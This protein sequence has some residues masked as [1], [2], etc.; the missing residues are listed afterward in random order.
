MRTL[1]G[2]SAY[3][4]AA[5]VGV[6][7]AVLI[8]GGVWWSLSDHPEETSLPVEPR[9]R[10]VRA[11]PRIAYVGRRTCAE[12]H[13]SQ[14]ETYLKTTHSRAL[15]DVDPSAEPPD[16]E[17]VHEPSQRAYRVYRRDGELRHEERL[18]GDDGEGLRLA[19]HPVKYVIGSGNHSRSYLV[20][21]DGF[22]VESPITWY[23]RKDAWGMSPG[24]DRPQHAGFERPTDAGCLVCHV[25]RLE[26]I[27]G[28]FH[29]IRI[30]E[31]AIGCE[32]CHGPGAQHVALHRGGSESAATASQQF[33][34][35]PSRLSR[36]RTEAIC[37]QCHLRGQATVYHAG[38]GV[39]SF[40]P[41][42]LLA[43]VRTDYHLR[44]SDGSMTVTGHVE[45][46]RMSR[47]WQASDS[48]TCTTCHDPHS[49]PEPEERLAYFRQ[50]CLECHAQDAC[51]LHE[52]ERLL[53]QP[54]DNC[55]ACHMPQSPTDIPHFAFTHH[56]IGIHESRESTQ[57][58]PSIGTLVP[59][60]DVDGLSPA[61]RQ[62]GLGLAYLELSDHHAGSQE[63]F[64]EYR[65]RAGTLLE[66]TLDRTPDD[67]QVLAALARLYWDRD[68]GRAIELATASLRTRE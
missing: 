5:Q 1:P 32:N 52:A 66:S 26:N 65:R 61:A 36:D 46:M 53:Q 33:I 37:A 42:Q 54:L 39:H 2:K 56:R 3:L 59:L 18:A 63:A 48:L 20:E 21:A 25:G 41:G 19:D 44:E 40:Q 23:A 67:G 10:S 34:V 24:Y 45:Q 17:F 47:C 27:G 31:Q 50:T 15:D 38:Y 57:N 13:P 12:C 29:R 43:E 55:V 22:L 64:N 58:G 35:H 6:I 49:E 4:V 28:S 11:E 9:R 8:S 7:A 14:H 51:G 68:P 16:V 62:R 30:H 60:S